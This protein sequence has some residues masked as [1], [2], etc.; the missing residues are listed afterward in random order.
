M[1]VK[2]IARPDRD[3]LGEGP[4]WV[5]ALGR[6]FWVDIIGHAVRWLDLK[7]G[8]YGSHVFNEPIGWIMPR[9]G[10]TD[11]IVG[12]KSGFHVFD[13]ESK[14]L[15]LIGD[16][17]PDRPHNRLNDAKVDGHGRIWAGTKDD[18]DQEK[19]GALYR[20]DTD[21]TWSQHDDGYAVT[22]G[23]AFSLDGRLMY[24]TDSG[25]RC[26]YAFDLAADGTLS[27]KKVFLRF[28]DDWGFPDGMTTDSENCL[29]VA[30]WGG[31]RISRF[32]PDGA[33]LRSIELPAS[34]ITSIAFAGPKLDRMF[35][36]SSA[37]GQEHEPAAGALF[38]VDPGVT[39]VMPRAFGG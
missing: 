18:R 20:L 13:F 34:N 16:P 24:H 35:V 12:M 37:D 6:L 9:A 3:A 4:V 32:S 27:G 30:H 19:S 28:E 7:T 23:P 8:A 36:T 11:F 2:P 31:G 22:N 15:T 17:E 33:L 25:A 29:W 14:A 21:L 1:P 39:G 10:R 5:P 26:I 38:E